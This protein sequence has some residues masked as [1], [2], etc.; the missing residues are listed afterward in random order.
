MSS[1]L[2]STLSSSASS[3][4]FVKPPPRK[5][6]SCCTTPPACFHRHHHHQEAE[7]ATISN[8][9][10]RSLT[11]ILN[12]GVIACLRTQRGD[13]A[14]EAARAAISAGISVLEIVVSTPGVFQV[15]NQLVQD[16]PTITL[17]VG[18]VL[19]T[20]DAENAKIAG[21]K[22]IMSPAFVKGILDQVSDELLYIPGVM[23]PSEILSSYNA[24]AK[25]V[26]VYPVSAIGGVQ[27]I[28]TMKKPFPHIPI[29]ASQGITID[30]LG[31]YIAH[32]ASSVVLSD[33][34]F[35]KEAIAQRNFNSV[36]RLAQ[37]AVLQANKA[38]ERKRKS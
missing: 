35:D 2:L 21:A 14:L 34:I 27:Y 1:W 8:T 5:A 37:L 7:A 26:K 16:Y 25:I 6:A 23:T 20:E 11:N 12:S 22:F 32:G 31:E 3:C 33:A 30:S 29:V 15:L 18:T 19:T 13:V 9:S 28:A 10:T 24:G 4:C 36:Y 17:G 38:V